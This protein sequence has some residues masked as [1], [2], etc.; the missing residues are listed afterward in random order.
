MTH[1]V[2]PTLWVK[3]VIRQRFQDELGPAQMLMMRTQ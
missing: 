2:K 1:D 3:K